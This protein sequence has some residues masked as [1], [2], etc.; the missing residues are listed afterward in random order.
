MALSFVYNITGDKR[1]L[2]K[3]YAEMIEYGTWPDWSGFTSTLVT[4]EILQGYA[5]CYDWLYDDLTAEQKNAIIEIVKRQALPDFIYAYNGQI[6]NTHFVTGTINWNPVCNATIIAW[7]IATANETPEIS[8]Y[9]LE[10]VPPLIQHALPPYGPQGGYPEGV[11]YWD[12]GTTFLCMI[13]DMLDNNFVA[14]FE[15]P[16]KYKYYTYPGIS[17]TGDFPI[18][19]SSSV[20]KFDYGDAAMGSGG[21]ASE[22]TP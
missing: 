14:G 8:E 18:Y 11:S 19:Y 15:L 4:A 13:M 16:E 9:I 1:Y 2:D 5:Y 12:Y 3:A 7:A 22:A 10:T 20:G 6:S 21:T 17:E